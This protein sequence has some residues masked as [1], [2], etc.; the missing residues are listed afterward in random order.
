MMKRYDPKA[1]WRKLVLEA[2][3][4]LV[5]AEKDPKEDGEDSLD[6]QVDR[7][8]TDFEAEAKS[9]KTEARDWRRTVRR[10]VEAE[11]DEGEEDKEDKK[12]EEGAEGEGEEEKPKKLSADDIDVD[13]YANSVMRL[14]DNYDSLL[15]VRNTILRRAANFIG[16]NYEMDVLN[17]FKETLRGDYGM[18]IGRSP[19]DMTD[20]KFPA[21]PAARAGG[22]GGGGGA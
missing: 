1:K 21:P 14:I 11:G 13:S 15:E 20:E 10:I 19:E 8:L 16:K 18:E 22:T 17:Q 12:D 7:Y 6:D 5:E 4:V 3:R 2:R 9:A